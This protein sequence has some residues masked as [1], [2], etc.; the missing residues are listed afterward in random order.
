MTTTDDPMWAQ[1]K[2]WDDFF[3]MWEAKVVDAN[4]KIVPPNVRGELSLWLGM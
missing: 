2:P 1:V 4:G 3:H